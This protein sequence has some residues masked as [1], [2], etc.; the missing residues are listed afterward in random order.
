MNSSSDDGLQLNRLTV[1]TPDAVLLQNAS[2]AFESGKITLLIGASGVGKSVLLR[3]LAGLIDPERSDVVV[4]GEIRRNGETVSRQSAG[5]GVVFQSLALFDELSPVENVHLGASHRDQEPDQKLTPP[6]PVQLLTE[7]GVPAKTP[8]P[9]LSGGQR[10]RVAIARTLAQGP[11]IVLYDEPTSGLDAANGRRVARLIARTQAS[12]PRTCIIVTHDFEPLLEVADAVVLIDPRDHSLRAIPPD[13]WSRLRQ[14]IEDSSQD[15]L[16]REGKH[17]KEIVDPHSRRPNRVVRAIGLFFAGTGKVIEEFVAAP[18]RLLPL[19]KSPRWG[20]RYARHYFGLVAGPSAWL[21]MLAA[22]GIIGFVTTY[23]TFRFLPY[24]KYTEP[25]LIENLLASMGFALFRILVPV[26]ATILIAARCGAAIASDVGGKVYGR[27]YDVLSTFGIRPDAYWLTGTLWA[28][29]IGTPLLVGI[30]Y[31]AA[32]TTSLAV[33]T[34][35][36]PQLGPDFW[37]LHYHRQID[38]PG[39]ILYLGWNWWLAKVLA[40]GIGTG[41]IAYHLAGSPKFSPDAVSRGITRT[42]LWASLYVLLVHFAFA[43][44]EFD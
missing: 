12:H 37:N 23:F 30:A 44:V 10:Q 34:W 18:I 43:F 39:H 31:V 21:Y 17:D 38:G 16:D 7:L 33:F 29:L 15:S 36:R 14:V 32:S 9:L 6:D 28:F 8:T 2:A 13:E 3:V 4:E 20:W 35:I 11:A 26:F 27:Q 40:C 42:I 5:V 25:L 24:A 41:Q 1:R 22:G 19:W